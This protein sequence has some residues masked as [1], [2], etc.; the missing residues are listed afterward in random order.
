MS[1][2]SH[3][4]FDA[5][6]KVVSGQLDAISQ[7]AAT[8][9]LLSQGLTPIEVV[10][11]KAGILMRLNIPLDALQ[12]PGKRDIYGFTR[13]LARMTRSGL[14]LERALALANEVAPN[15]QF[16]RQVEDIQKGVRK[17]NSFAAALAE[18]KQLFPPHYVA[19]IHAGEM[20][21]KL[22]AA[23]EQL[24]QMFSRQL[25]FA[26]R[27]RS[28]LIYPTV[29]LLMVCITMVLVVTVVLPQFAPLFEGAEDRLPW[30]TQAVLA[31]GELFRQLGL[32]VLI[33]LLVGAVV[34]KQQLKKPAVQKRFGNWLLRNKLM[35][36]LVVPVD[37]IRVV[38]TLGGAMQGGVKL[39]TALPMAASTAHNSA[40]R[41]SLA[42]MVDGVRK[43]QFFSSQLDNAVW[44]TPLLLQ[45][46]RV[47]EE[48]GR[49]G[50]M[51]QNAAQLME[52]DYH[53]TLERFLGLLSP[54]LTLLM[55]AMVA[56]LVGAVLV[57]M[58]SINDVAF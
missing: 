20:S 45:M 43:G 36:K 21:G 3:R 23:L 26:E 18:Q 4:S 8:E 19:A 15:K 52:D 27:L 41:Q 53:T 10:A 1:E 32:F 29:L 55:G 25:A 6:G 39:D 56:V 51:L 40:I 2:F 16:A 44:T 12:K 50:E 7:A 24:E 48:T 30:L 17:G 46:V 28:A 34:I 9:Q 14:P 33:A 49:L 31:F 38:R 35:Q 13:D 22:P 54:L 11:G 5:S 37:I 47:G 42:D 58:M 57:G